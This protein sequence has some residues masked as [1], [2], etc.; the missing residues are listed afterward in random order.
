MTIYNKVLRWCEVNEQKNDCNVIVRQKDIAELSYA[1]ISRYINGNVSNCFHESYK[2]SWLKEY[3]IEGK[4]ILVYLQ[5][6][7]TSK[8]SHY[9]V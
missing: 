4:M 6:L 5:N 1:S 7:I 8:M 3:F 2:I 9:N